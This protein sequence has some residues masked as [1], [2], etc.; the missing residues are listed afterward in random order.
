MAFQIT[1]LLKTAAEVAVEE[2]TGEIELEAGTD[3]TVP[4]APQV[5]SLQGK[6]V[7]LKLTLTETKPTF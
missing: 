4:F 5:A 3:V 1:D 7:Y 6:P 2:Q